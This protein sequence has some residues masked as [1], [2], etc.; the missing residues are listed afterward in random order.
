MKSQGSRKTKIFYPL[1]LKSRTSRNLPFA[2]TVPS[3]VDNLWH[4]FSETIRKEYGRE[5]K[6]WASLLV[7][8]FTKKEKRNLLFEDLVMF[9]LPVQEGLKLPHDTHLKSP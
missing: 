1:L 5:K 4:Y 6:S 7:G 3:Q 9:W 8:T 2:N